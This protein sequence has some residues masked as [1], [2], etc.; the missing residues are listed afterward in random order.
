[1]KRTTKV[2]KEY[3][4]EFIGP[5][6]H[7]TATGRVLK[8]GDTHRAFPSEIEPFKAK[9][10]ALEHVPDQNEKEEKEQVVPESK[11]VPVHKGG[12]RY[13]VI[14]EDSNEIVTDGYLGKDDAYAMCGMDPSSKKSEPGEDEEP[15]E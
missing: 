7:V 2:E 9:F 15:N 4:Y 13:I 11:L 12:G 6:A 10:R 1:M 5:G 14:Q 3:R 8:K